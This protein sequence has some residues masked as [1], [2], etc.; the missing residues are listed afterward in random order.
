MDVNSPKEY[1][2]SLE[3]QHFVKL[4]KVYWKI[5]LEILGCFMTTTAMFFFA[6]EN[7]FSM[8]IEISIWYY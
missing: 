5:S 3:Q 2:E 1:E 8:Q 6:M 4:G 7:L